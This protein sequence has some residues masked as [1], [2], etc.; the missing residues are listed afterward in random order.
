MEE[1]IYKKIKP[2]KEFHDC[3]KDSLPRGRYREIGEKARTTSC[4]VL[5][6]SGSGFYHTPTHDFA[7]NAGEILFISEGEHYT[8]SV[9]CDDYKFYCINFT[10]GDGV[11][12]ESESLKIKNF[13]SYK[14]LF[15]ELTIAYLKEKASYP[16]CCLS[17]FYEIYSKIIEDYTT[18]NNSADAQKIQPSYEYILENFTD[19]D[20]NIPLLA[21]M[22]NVSEVHYRRLFR[23]VYKTSPLKFIN[24][25]RLNKARAMLEKREGTVINIAFSCGFSDLYY[26]SRVYKTH[27]GYPPSQTRHC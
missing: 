12:R 3:Y 26:F 22:C 27:F 18:Y 14:N 19:S 21:A 2:I 9:N 20:I 6:L 8:I 17:K 1:K 15:S 5:I 11:K 16:I 10:W 25:L 24:T 4:L 23:K 13:E 7:A